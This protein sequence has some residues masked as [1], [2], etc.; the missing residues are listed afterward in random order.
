[1]TTTS[2]IPAYVW[3]SEPE[4]PKFINAV[5]FGPAGAGKS[6]A[7]ATAP[8]PIYVLNL[9][10][11]NALGYARKIARE[12]GVQ[13]NVLSLRHDEDPR[14]ALREV[15]SRA[16]EKNGT[17]VVDTFGKYRDQ[18]A[19]AIGG[20]QPSLPQWGQ[21][22]K[23]I[24]EAVR[25]MRDLPCNVVLICHEEIKDS[26]EGDRIIR[27]LIGGRTTEDV[28]GEMDVIAYCAAHRTE[29]GIA[30]VGQLVTEKGRRAKDRSGAL[31]SVRPL[32]LTEW[33][34]TYAAAL[35]APASDDPFTEESK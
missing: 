28:M 17:L 29:E 21:I 9:E 1:M 5:L 20:D 12:R 13:F 31:G 26:D 8:S 7:A 18:T 25:Q 27:P 34:E 19:R 15:M 2:D 4:A 6:S 33:L 22:G 24:M 32:D 23:S 14:P 35:A 30:Y 3:D 11:G 16:A 10:G